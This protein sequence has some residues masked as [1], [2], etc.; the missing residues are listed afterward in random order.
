MT[1][2]EKTEKEIKE[3]SDEEID[4]LASGAENPEFVKKMLKEIKSKPDLPGDEV[5]FI[6]WG[7][8]RAM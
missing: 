5:R 8:S 4:Q 3:M 1:E 6:Q 7:W 2:I